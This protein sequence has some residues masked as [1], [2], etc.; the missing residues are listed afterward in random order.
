MNS[1]GGSNQ[2]DRTGVPFDRS[3]AL[4]CPWL[5]GLAL[6][7][8]GSVTAEECSGLV[9]HLAS[10]CPF[11]LAEQGR[12]EEGWATKDASDA[13]DGAVAPVP[14]DGLRARLHSES[15]PIPMR[16]FDRPWR[17]L[18]SAPVEVLAGEL[19]MVRGGKAGYEPTG[20]E[21]IEIKPL[22]V[23]SA[24]RRLTMLIRMAPNTSYPPHRHASTEECFVVSGEIRV[25]GRVLYAGDYQVAAEGLIHGVQSTDTGCV[26][27]IISSQDD[28][29]L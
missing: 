2:G 9:E 16:D 28:E 6:Y 11:C 5:D 22:H 20:I 7:V 24:R 25:G 1:N 26:L 29:L 23:D 8:A 15:K 10:G 4:A 14:R 17:S 3:S 13:Q 27:L 18:M 12:L 21:G 19:A